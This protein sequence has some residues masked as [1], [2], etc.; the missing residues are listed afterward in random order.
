MAEMTGPDGSSAAV[1][2]ASFAEGASGTPKRITERRP[3]ATRGVRKGTRRLRPRRCWLGR[4]GMGVSSSGLSVMK[5]GYMSIAWEISLGV[6]SI[7]G[8]G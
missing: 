4:E 2:R 7:V 6:C 1:P 8:Q 3:F 5:R